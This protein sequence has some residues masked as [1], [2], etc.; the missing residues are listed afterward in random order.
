MNNLNWLFFQCLV[1][2]C[3]LRLAVVV[4]GIVGF[5]LEPRKL[6]ETE[7]PNPSLKSLRPSA[8]NL[9]FVFGLVY[10]SL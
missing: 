6:G 5:P 3:G 2:G 7:V 4:T 10:F 8:E 9:C 1:V